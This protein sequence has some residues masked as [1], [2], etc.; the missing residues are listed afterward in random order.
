M[1]DPLLEKIL[2]LEARL[3]R[4]EVDVRRADRTVTGMKHFLKIAAEYQNESPEQVVVAIQAALGKA[5]KYEG[6]Q[7]T[8][9]RKR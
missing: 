3:D 7:P 6:R 1:V 8:K 5:S 4:L 2:D 9:R